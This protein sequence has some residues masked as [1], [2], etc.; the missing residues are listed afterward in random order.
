MITSRECYV[1][2]SILIRV[3]AKIALLQQ[4]FQVLIYL[5]IINCGILLLKDPC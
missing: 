5:K 1:E 4:L 2:R 3:P